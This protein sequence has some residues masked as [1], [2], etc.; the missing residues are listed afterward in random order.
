VGYWSQVIQGYSRDTSGIRI[1]R[2]KGI[3]STHSLCFPCCVNSPHSTSE[4]VLAMSNL[5]ERIGPKVGQNKS[6]IRPG[7][8]VKHSSPKQS[9]T[10]KQIPT[11]AGYE[12]DQSSHEADSG[13]RDTDPSHPDF[14]NSAR[15]TSLLERMGISPG[16]DSGGDDEDTEAVA[17]SLIER[18]GLVSG[19]ESAYKT[20]SKAQ[21]PDNVDPF[22][23]DQESVNDL[24]LDV[25]PVAH[26]SVCQSYF[27]L[28]FSIVIVVLR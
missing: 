15:K 2:R 19:I 6:W 16:I 13:H 9:R 27:P 12:S 11:A 21:T 28:C 23:K 5:K 10:R 1:T 20:L 8:Q 3:L 14:R 24:P 17:K 7:Y 22:E 26:D 18:V 4:Q 25:L